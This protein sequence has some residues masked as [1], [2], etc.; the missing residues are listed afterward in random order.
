M[1][2]EAV[3][4]KKKMAAFLTVYKVENENVK[5]YGYNN[6]Q[7]EIKPQYKTVFPRLYWT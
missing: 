2:S 1:Y 3:L 4:I 6:S 7:S 5:W